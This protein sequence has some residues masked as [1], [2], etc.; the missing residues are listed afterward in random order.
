METYSTPTNIRPFSFWFSYIQNKAKLSKEDY[1]SG[2][3]ILGSF[4][5]IED[6]W[7][8]Y[9]HMIRPDKLP[10][11]C[12][13]A[14][15]QEGIKPAWEDKANEDGGSFILRI[16]RSHANKIWEDLVLSYI[17]EQCK[18]NNEICGLYLNVKATEAN[19]SI[20]T[21]VIDQNKRDIIREWIKETL[22]FGDKIEVEYKLHPKEEAQNQPAKGGDR[23]NRGD[24]VKRV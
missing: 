6:F 9:Q 10:A 17:G 8:Y 22:G 5:T 24:N 4:S 1:E 3:K 13:F 21:K 2:I 16:R 20:W 19:I 11:G 14:L 15:F 18:E 12:K 7:S 23:F